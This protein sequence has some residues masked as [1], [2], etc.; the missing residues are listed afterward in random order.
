MYKRQTHH[1]ATLAPVGE[2]DRYRLLTAPGPIQRL[3]VLDDALDDIEAVLRFR[4]GDTEPRC[5]AGER[6][7]SDGQGAV[8]RLVTQR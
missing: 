3:D 4:L 2:A 8:E 6:S 1:L 5:G 7:R